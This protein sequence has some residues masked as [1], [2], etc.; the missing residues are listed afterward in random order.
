MSK[1]PCPS[2]LPPFLRGSPRAILLSS[3][4][5]GRSSARP[6][7]MA[8]HLCST[9]SPAEARFLLRRCAVGAQAQTFDY[10][11]VAA[12]LLKVV[13]EEIPRHDGRLAEAVRKRGHGSKRECRPTAAPSIRPIPTVPYR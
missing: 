6:T 1:M 3:N 8:C 4:V 10:N 7:Q 13:L 11:P 2:S 9:H 12:L 5:V